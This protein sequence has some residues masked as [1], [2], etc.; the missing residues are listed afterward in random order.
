MEQGWLP[1]HRLQERVR[2]VRSERG[3]QYFRTV[4]LGNGLS[5]LEIEEET[6]EAVFEHLWSLTEGRRVRKR[7]YYVPD[8]SVLWEIDEF[9]DRDLVLAEVEL[10]SPE[11]AVEV[12]PWLAEVL[13][14]DVTGEAEFL[15]VN[16]AC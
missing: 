15:N 8:G 12:P 5:R 9:V 1:G 6:T 11:T 14:R 16:L 7:R 13:V 10:A 4:K 3:E 2:R